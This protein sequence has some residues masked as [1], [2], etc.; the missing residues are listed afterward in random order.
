M[1]TDNQALLPKILDLLIDTVCVVDAEGRFVFLSAS[2]ERLFG[3]TPEELIGRNMIEL[4]HPQD[5]ARTLTAVEDIMAGRPHTHFQN[6]YVRKDGQAVHIMWSARWSEADGVRLAVA[7]DITELKRAERVQSALYQISEAAHRAGGLPAL[8]SSIHQII[9]DL[10]PADNFYVAL[11]D[12]VH[13]TLTFP[14]F[15]DERQQGP[16]PQ[17]LSA[18]TPA[19]EVIRTNRALLATIGSTAGAAAT[20][21][22]YAD[23]LGV[24]LTA[25]SGTIGALAVQSCSAAVHY[26]EEH[27][28][29]LEF[30]STQ[31]AS[32]IERKQNETRMLHL[33]QHDPLTDLPNR[34]LL[35]D[36]LDK[37]LQRARRE[38]EH[39]ALIYLD[40][41][42]FKQVND[43]YGHE[44][45][46]ELLKAV[47][48]RISCCI[49]ESDT[50]GRMS[51]DEF[52]VLAT[53][54]DGAEA[55]DRV[56]EKIR[57]SV[58]G[59]YELGGHDVAITASIGVAVYPDDAVGKKALFRK[60]DTRMYAVKRQQRMFAAC[61]G[62]GSG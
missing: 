34:M 37:A 41:D 17:P 42:G 52:T 1:T 50:V 22:G 31:V 25:G 30:V 44:A 46:D 13:D 59:T 10:L 53:R 58:N 29:L 26:T 11:Y 43:R 2:C 40:L 38:R 32:A 9:D 7:R 36:R 56:A 28:E 27:K 35:H 16:A 24:P 8:Y 51:G 60:A 5:R 21:Q 14:Y 61:E 4:V 55:A 39:L 19:A 33:A 15:I 20:G 18:D 62:T 54:I 6:R 45:G 12:A 23:W 3:Y 49:R 47:A 48:R 57:T